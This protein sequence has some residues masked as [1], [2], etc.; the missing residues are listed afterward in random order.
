MS[1]KIPKEQLFQLLIE[2]QSELIKMGGGTNSPPEALNNDG[3][4]TAFGGG[5]IT[6]NEWLQ[7]VFVPNAMDCVADEKIPPTS[8]VGVMAVKEYDGNLNA[9][10]LINKLIQFDDIINLLG[11]KVWKEEE[12]SREKNRI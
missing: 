6:F 3:P 2:I 11:K 12:K 10:E 8:A 1:K 9:N 4:P 5:K 7:W